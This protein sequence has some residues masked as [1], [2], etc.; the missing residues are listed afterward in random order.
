MPAHR[1]RLAQAR[2]PEPFLLPIFQTALRT[3]KEFHIGLLRQLWQATRLRYSHCRLDPWEYYFF[4]VYLDRYPMREKVR[5]AGWRKEIVLDRLANTGNARNLANNKLA[6]YKLMSAHDAPLPK[7]AATYGANNPAGPGS[8]LLT[9]P[10]TAAD[11]LRDPAHFP[12]FIKPVRGAHG[13]AARALA[14]VAGDQLEH[15][16]GEKQSVE[17][18]IAGLEQHE[19]EGF[20]FQEMLRPHENIRALCGDRLTTIRII[21]ILTAAGPEIISAVWRVPTGNNITDNFNVGQSGNLVAGIELDTGCIRNIVQGDGW[22]IRPTDHHPDTGIELKG[23]NLPDWQKAARL[24]LNYATHFP[25]LRLQH[26][27]IALTDHGPVILEINVEGGLR[28]HQ[29]VARRGIYGKRLQTIE[30]EI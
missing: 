6:F 17:S 29:V 25:E 14:N 19:P 2:L 23:R 5:F 13:W 27:D 22:K 1:T 30:N 16:S 20:L 3:R 11:F 10:R 28:T 12:L 18:F 9:D 7:L 15:Q 4:Q 8:A 24:C 21:V 26:W